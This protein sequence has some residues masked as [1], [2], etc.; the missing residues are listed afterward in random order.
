MGTAGKKHVVKTVTDI[1][2]LKHC[3]LINGVH[4]DLS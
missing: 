3:P 4:S 2:K 1:F